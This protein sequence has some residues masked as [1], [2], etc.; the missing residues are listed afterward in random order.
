M[1][2]ALVSHLLSGCAALL[3]LI[4]GVSAPK[5]DPVADNPQWYVFTQ[6]PSSPAGTMP[7]YLAP[8]SMAIRIMPTVAA[9]KALVT[10]M[11]PELPLLVIHAGQS[12]LQSLEQYMLANAPEAQ[13]SWYDAGQLDSYAIGDYGLVAVASDQGPLILDPKFDNV[14]KYDDAFPSRFATQYAGSC[15]FRPP[16]LFQR[17][18]L[19]SNGE[20]ICLLSTK[21]YTMNPNLNEL[22]VRTAVSQ[23]FG[24]SKVVPVQPLQGDGKGRIDILFRF[25][26]ATTLLA[27]LYDVSQDAP[28]RSIMLT[29]H[30]ALAK[31]LPD[32]TVSTIVMPDPRPEPGDAAWPSYLNFVVTPQSLLYPSFLAVDSTSAE[33]GLEAA[34][35]KALL[36][37]FPSLQPLPVSASVLLAIGLRLNSVVLP[38][39]A[40]A[41]AACQQ[42][43]DRCTSNTLDSCE[44][45][46]DEC[47]AIGNS[48]LTETS[49]SVCQLGDNGCLH[50][51]EIECQENWTCEGGLCKAPPNPCDTMPDEG[52][53]DG[54]TLKKCNG[55]SLISVD[56]WATGKICAADPETDKP[57]CVEFCTSDCAESESDRCASQGTAVEQCIQGMDGCLHWTSTQC[58]SASC[59]GG[60]C[61]GDLNDI[62]SDASDASPADLSGNEDQGFG[63]GFAPKKGCA[64]TPSSSPGGASPFAPLILLISL[65]GL[66]LARRRPTGRRAR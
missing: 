52:L 8:G 16:L 3:V 63:G 64:S 29:N 49:R 6:P 22:Q 19:E 57:A 21:I 23:Y 56:C 9:F 33:K 42:P 59:Q 1:Q 65:A 66:I 5:A 25:T 53:C 2:R 11:A 47:L 50:V 18:I 24:C 35:E 31:A 4:G 26:S 45:C 13:V 15:A 14:D 51:Q 43:L 34:A 32:V 20:G 40:D 36:D 62:A 39:P 44:G 55:S 54:D 46:F 12:E 30:Q 27:G 41:W 48:C 17:G 10:A 28:N 37:A 38:L 61:V 60:K 58:P 7:G